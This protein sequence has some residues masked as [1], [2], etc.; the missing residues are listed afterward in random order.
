[1]NWI[2]F[3]GIILITIVSNQLSRN[4]LLTTLWLWEFWMIQRPLDLNMYWFF[5]PH[6]N[7][8]K[9]FE[10]PNFKSGN[11]TSE[12]SWEF[13]FLWFSH[14]YHFVRGYVSLSLTCPIFHTCIQKTSLSSHW[15]NFIPKNT[16]SCH[17]QKFFCKSKLGLQ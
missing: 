9:L 16:F 11:A 6:S 13:F 14:T 12:G 5:K 17:S 2:W 3:G 4:S 8:L 7:E 15:F 1:M 10:G